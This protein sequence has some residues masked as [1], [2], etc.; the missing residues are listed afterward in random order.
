MM[1]NSHPSLN[2]GGGKSEVF[3]KEE[4]FHDAWAG[5]VDP[6]TIDVVKSN[7]AHV[8][9]EL[10]YVHRLLKKMDNGNG[11]KGKKILD[12]G[13]GLGET[14]VYFAMQ[15][16]DVVAAD[17]SWNM[18]EVTQNLAKQYGVKLTTHQTTAENLNFSNGEQ[19]DIVFANFLMHHVNIK[20]TLLRVKEVLK[21][22]GMFIC[23]DPVA[24]NPVINVYRALSKQ[25]HTEDEHPFTKADVRTIKSIFP[26]VKIKFFWLFTLVVYVLM[27][28]TNNPNKVRFWKKVVEQ[29][30]K[31]KYLYVPL[32]FLDR[33]FL[34]I[35]PFLGWICNNIVVVA[36]KSEN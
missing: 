21:P 28:V 12:L 30:G 29:D 6:A 24:Y 1:F 32:S 8:L 5:S 25:L 14:S 16:A 26:K 15:G 20:E 27:A 4:R 36:Y 11:L 10:R 31:W 2:E 23:C 35:F 33:L 13:C 17:I 9:P 3:E 34:A 7:T 18:L 19:F 22:D